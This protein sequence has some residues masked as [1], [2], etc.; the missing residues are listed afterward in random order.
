[1][2]DRWLYLRGGDVSLLIDARPGGE[3]LPRVL[4]FGADLGAAPDFDA[5]AAT[6]PKVLWGARL[7]VPCPPCVMPGAEAGYFGTPAI[8]P[9]YASRWTFDRV[10]QTA[11]GFDLLFDVATGEPRNAFVRI[12]YRMSPH[13]VLASRACV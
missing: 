10:D 8:V 9:S 4:H 7:D 12:E 11:E 13:G 3:A 2:K 5:I 6:A 1:M